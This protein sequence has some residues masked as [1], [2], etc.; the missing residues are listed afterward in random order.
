MPIYEF[1]CIECGTVFEKLLKMSESEI[2]EI[3]CPC[4]QKQ[5][6]LKIV[7]ASDFHLKGDWYKTSGKY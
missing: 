7:S 1:A 3:E 2:R 5:P 6:A 4:E